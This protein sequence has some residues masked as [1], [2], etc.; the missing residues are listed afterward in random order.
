[1]ATPMSTS[2]KNPQR[3]RRSDTDR[4]HELIRAVVALS[5]VDESGMPA[6]PGAHGLEHIVADVEID[7]SRYLLVPIS[8][9]ERKTSSLSPREMEIVRMVAQGHPNKIIAVVL[10][11]SSWTVCTHLRRIFAKL[12]VSSRAA[13]VARLLEPS[14][15]LDSGLATAEKILPAAQPRPGALP[16][17]GD[18]N[19]RGLIRTMGCTVAVEKGKVPPVRTNKT[20]IVFKSTIL[21]WMPWAVVLL[22]T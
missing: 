9:G 1:M 3:S 15:P 12:G 16:A 2:D 18:H 17:S 8:A 19:A 13:M 22:G 14:R 6:R 5:N 4:L 7:G 20:G 21:A 11:I 10:N